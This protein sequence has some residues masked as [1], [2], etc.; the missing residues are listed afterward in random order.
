MKQ[1]SKRATMNSNREPE[2][3]SN[4]RQLD[5][6][7]QSAKSRSGPSRWLACVADF[8]AGAARFHRGRVV[9]AQPGSLGAAP[10]DA[11]RRPLP[12]ADIVRRIELYCPAVKPGVG[13][14]SRNFTILAGQRR[15]REP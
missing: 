2:A 15:S 11:R 3:A 12:P 13:R 7:G 9:R 1:N 5:E 8:E 4:L 6:A 10:G 14:A